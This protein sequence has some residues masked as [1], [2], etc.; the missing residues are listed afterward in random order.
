MSKNRPGLGILYV[1]MGMSKA[2]GLGKC[3]HLNM[4]GEG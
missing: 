3:T 1:Y 4:D 2:H